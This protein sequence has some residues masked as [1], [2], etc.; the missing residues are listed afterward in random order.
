[1]AENLKFDV[2]I[3]RLACFS[4]LRQFS[5]C[6]CF[7]YMHV[8]PRVPVM[9]TAGAWRTDGYDRLYLTVGS[10]GVTGGGG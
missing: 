3:F 10:E 5:F 8:F 7:G 9:E 1:M 4:D 2:I 6:W